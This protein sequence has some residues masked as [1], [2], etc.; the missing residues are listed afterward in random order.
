[1]LIRLH[2]FGRFSLERE[3]QPIRFPTRKIETL[4]AYLVLNP[5]LHSRE[6]LAAL[7]WGDFDDAQARA[8][9]RNALALLRKHIGAGLLLADRES[10]QLNPS[11][12]LWVDAVEF[13]KILSQRSTVTTATLESLITLYRGDL[14][15]DFYDEW[16]FSER[17]YY[18]SL[19]LE[20]LLGL[21]DQLR[22][23]GEY[24]RAIDLS[25]RLLNS[26][27]TNEPA[28]QTLMFCYFALGNRTAAL[29]QYELCRRALRTE[30]EVDPQPETTALYE[31]LKR[32]LIASSSLAA[33]FTNL[34]TPLTNFIGRTQELT[35][36]EQL[37]RTPHNRL[38]T[39]TG[40]GG[41]GKT[42]LS[43]EAAHRV[44]N[45][46]DDGVWWVELAPVTDPVF[47]PYTVAKMLG[48]REGVEQPLEETLL[49]HLR[50]KALLLLLDNCEH[51]IIACAQL[52]E[53][54]L[55]ACPRLQ[56]LATSREALGLPGE[57][58]WL[59]P[60]LSLPHPQQR[61]TYEDVQQSEAAQLFLHRASA[62]RSDFV[63]TEQNASAVVRLCQQ[64]DGI[65]LALELAAVWVKALPVE[66]I[67]ARLTD[68]LAILT[69]GSHTALP[70][71][72]TLR[73]TMD[74]SYDLLSAQ[75]QI[76]FYR[77]SV[78]VAGFTLAAAEA[79]WLEQDEGETQEKGGNIKGEQKFHPFTIVDL[80]TQLVN[81]SFVLAEYYGTEPRYRLLEPVRQYGEDKLWLS[82]QEAAIRRRHLQWCLHLAEQAEPEL[83]GPNQDLWLE[84]LEREYA[85][86]NAAL[87]WSAEGEP[88]DRVA[89]LHLGGALWWFWGLR[90]YYVEG[91]ERLTPLLAWPD[92]ASEPEA[93]AKALFSA[94]ML[95]L[96]QMDSSSATRLLQESQALWRALD[97]PYGL[98][99]TEQYL[100]F[101]AHRQGQ[102][103]I[104]RLK[105]EASLTLWRKISNPWG[106]GET[107]GLLGNLTYWDGDYATAQA[108]QE[109]SLQFKRQLGEKRGIAF[110]V[111]SLGKVTQAQGDY[112]TARTLYAEA[113]TIMR[114][115]ENKEGIPFVLEAYGYL[116][117]AKAQLQ[118]AARLFGAAAAL[119][120]AIGSA[121]PVISQADHQRHIDIVR[122]NL[123]DIIFI[124]L[125]AEGQ[126]MT[127]DQMVDYALQSL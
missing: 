58:V 86:L 102:P 63:L 44:E 105:Y 5:Q 57:R 85:N 42:R 73:A 47:V 113:I 45:H 7:L 125:W 9:L 21:A 64:L 91:R 6:K 19:Y 104:A 3:A 13:N 16:I 60:S 66:Q 101:M 1:M 67:A 22:S 117:V 15:A 127:L 115:L 53:K 34:P 49:T 35:E 99:L 10:V 96:Y 23:S 97:H 31:R 74:W 81:K 77:L 126:A 61:L 69:L 110:S 112:D 24:R 89:G 32:T 65:P 36:I 78:F 39:L 120:Q 28:H 26:D 100:G 25:E 54:L 95:A 108:L 109:E 62:A 79:I 52:V 119:R 122:I 72:Q 88:A 2:L 80:L 46:F 59:V 123:G 68:R 94:G 116:A 8:S 106:L 118:R 12:P 14:L 90:G 30:L 103:A 40:P 84:R 70:R 82:G 11:F 92:A 111:W 4:L 41:C 83:L 76:L 107:L 37:L 124:P 55:S 20:T 48:L 29:R 87:R 50:P 43:I 27:P 121:I 33:Q 114:L 56:I 93:H 51:L 75:E 17:E 71:H 98:A 18:H 38:I